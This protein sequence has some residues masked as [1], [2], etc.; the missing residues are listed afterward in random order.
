N[1]LFS[2]ELI[3]PD[4]FSKRTEM[5]LL[6][7]VLGIRLVFGLGDQRS[8]CPRLK[9]HGIC[10]GSGRSID[11]PAA[12]VHVTVVVGPNFRDDIRGMSGSDGS[13]PEL[14]CTH[15]T[16]STWDVQN[17]LSWGFATVDHQSGSSS[18]A[19]RASR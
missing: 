14:N 10:A 13:A 11:K 19:F 16:N 8:L 18:S 5:P 15:E 2:R 17:L 4:H 6:V 1:V 9:L 12:Q 3:G 7:S